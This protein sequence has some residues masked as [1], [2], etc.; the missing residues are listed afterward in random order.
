MSLVGKE[1]TLVRSSSQARAA[2]GTEGAWMV[3]WMDFAP[4]DA[5][6]RAP[7]SLLAHQQTLGHPCSAADGSLYA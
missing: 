4:T 2:A 7:I 3:S 1:E 6:C 5:P